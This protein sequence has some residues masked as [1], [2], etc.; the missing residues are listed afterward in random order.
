MF[1]ICCL[2]FLLD[3][4]KDGATQ[5]P[6][7]KPDPEKPNP[8]IGIGHVSFSNNC[9]FMATKNGMFSKKVTYSTSCM[10]VDTADVTVSQSLRF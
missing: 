5:I 6:Q 7:V 2:K 3:E 8:K 4:V 1:D 9:R 10:I